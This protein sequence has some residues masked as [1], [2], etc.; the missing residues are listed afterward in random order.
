M[1]T[2]EI[3]SVSVYTSND[4]GFSPEEIAER[5]VDRIL[6]VSESA[7]PEV[8]AQAHAYRSQLV[9][10]ITSYMKQA[11]SSDRTTIVNAL[12]KAGHK[13]LAEHIRSL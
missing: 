7:T 13:D 6:H 10:V 3:G 2:S 4:R 12:T 11:I 8:K 5:C 1:I 9:A